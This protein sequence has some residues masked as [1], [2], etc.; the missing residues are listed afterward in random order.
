[1][2]FPCA[3]QA[4]M[5]RGGVYGS[6]NCTSSRA[7]SRSVIRPQKAELIS[8]RLVFDVSEVAVASAAELPA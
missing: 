8:A 4:L 5:M 6:W 7:A 2:C 3:A 1:M